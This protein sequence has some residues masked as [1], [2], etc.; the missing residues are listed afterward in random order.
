M[1]Q[2]VLKKTNNYTLEEKKL[3]ERMI[4]VLVNKLDERDIQN[5]GA[6]MLKLQK[7]LEKEKK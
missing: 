7:K 5:S 3:Y 6:K 1:L 2:D 4:N